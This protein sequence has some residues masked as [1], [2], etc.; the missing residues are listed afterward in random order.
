MLSNG[1]P[2]QTVDDGIVPDAK[3][4]CVALVPVVASA[5]WSRTSG[6]QPSR[7]NSIFVAHL[8]AT[9]E[10]VPQTR[11]LRRATLADA[12]TAYRMNQHQARGGGVRTRQII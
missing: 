5:Q 10:Q 6:L 8:I 1:R 11:S 3:P 4:A 9:A 7:P 2:E 12:Q